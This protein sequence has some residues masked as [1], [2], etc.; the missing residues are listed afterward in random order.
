MA[1]VEAGGGAAVTNDK[2]ISVI[3][4]LIIW[5]KPEMWWKDREKS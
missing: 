1:E 2:N 3:F 5:K 4:F